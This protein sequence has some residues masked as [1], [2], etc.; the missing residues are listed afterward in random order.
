MTGARLC[1]V[2]I[3]HV[4]TDPVHHEVR[5]RSY[6]WLVDVDDLPRLPRPL[7][8]L[9]CFRAA[10]FLGDPGRSIRENVE[11]FVADH[12]IHLHG[13]RITL[14][15]NPR[16]LGY[17]F[18]PLSVF[19]CH[20]RTGALACVVAEV[21]NT[22]GAGHRY[23]LRPG[24]AEAVDTEKHLYVSPFYPVDGYYRISVPEPEDRVAI[25]VSLHRPDQRPFTASVRGTV[26]AATPLA[27]TRMLARRPVETWRVRAA[28][29]AH[30]LALWRKRLPVVPRS[31]VAEVVRPQHRADVAERIAGLV[32]EVAGLRL[33]VRLRAWDGSEAGP[34]EGPVL[35]LR[36]R[37]ALRRLLW[38]PGELGLA[39][40][41]VTGDIDVEGDLADGL[42]RAWALTE[43]HGTR[44]P[45]IGL[46]GRLRAAVVAARLGALG[47][48]PAAPLSEVRLRGPLHTRTRD[49]AAIAHHYDLS[50]D[51]YRLLLDE[52]MAYSAAYFSDA[53]QSLADAQRAKLDLICRK[54]DLR[55]GMRLLDVGCGWG[56]L[57]LHAAEHYGVRVTGITLSEQQRDFVAKRIADLGLSKRAEV[58]LQDYRE[59]AQEAEQF[60][61]VASVEMGEHV[62]QQQYP[63]YAATLFG[64]LVPQGRLLLQQMSRSGEA[65]PGGGAF[66]ES[67][68]AP[69]MHMRPVAETVGLLAGAGFEIHDVEAMREHY[70]LTVARW[71]TRF[72]ACYAQFV[73]MVGEE[74][75]RVWRLY[76]VGGG[77]SFE[78]GRMGVEQILGVRPG[79]GGVSRM[80]L[81]RRWTAAAAR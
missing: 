5:S 41:Y 17:S 2:T 14:L 40:A 46:G 30:G 67:Y 52:S 76:L 13:G 65:A 44:P 45:R 66:I 49:R 77:L 19:W 63:G 36:S 58:R 42:R 28:I 16:S 4:R 32:H 55:P 39:R 22:Y 57:V 62:G 71:L 73:A 68:I 3:R 34:S 20:D 37:R 21:H 74:V 72:E 7:R 10:D 25:T 54:L 26:R 43:S 81:T 38:A 1:D 59:L 24:G 61:A 6:L 31:P 50:N 51:F 23:L 69:D 79:P 53:A 9:A 70:V 29:T 8:A 12:G 18:N 11:T 80:P 35:V 78:Q 48:P 47:R 56:S 27:I 64:A 15:A 75:A 33:P 60:D